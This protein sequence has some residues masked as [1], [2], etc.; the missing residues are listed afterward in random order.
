MDVKKVL[1][2]LED[3]E[4]PTAIVKQM[5][6]LVDIHPAPAPAPAAPVHHASEGPIKSLPARQKGY[7]PYTPTPKPIHYSTPKPVYHSTIKPLIHHS[8]PKPIY[9]H[10]TAP[11]YH[12]HPASPAPPVYH[13]TTLPP[14]APLYHHPTTTLKPI[15]HH[16]PPTTPSPLAPHHNVPIYHSTIKP[17]AFPHHISGPLPHRHHLAA[18]KPVLHHSVKPV[19]LHREPVALAATVKAKHCYL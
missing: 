7:G 4:E 12:P 1:D 18:V 15:L 8:T 6:K 2:S 3:I 10:A 11:L 9:H 19:L 5:P 17:V 16:A 14:T 13:T